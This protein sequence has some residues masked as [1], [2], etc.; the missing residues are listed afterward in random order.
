MALNNIN[1]NALD[2]FN[3]AAELEETLSQFIRV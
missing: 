3:G 1:W 2:K